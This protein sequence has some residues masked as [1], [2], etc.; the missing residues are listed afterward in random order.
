MQESI[1]HRR[2]RLEEGMITDLESLRQTIVTSGFV[3]LDAEPWVPGDPKSY[4]VSQIGVGYVPPV[5]I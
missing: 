2:K 3:T 1:Q 5:D 4:E